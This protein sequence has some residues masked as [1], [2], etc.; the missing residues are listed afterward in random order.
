MV[1]DSIGDCFTRLRNGS[2]ARRESVE[3]PHSKVNEKILGLLKDEGF[4][5]EVSISDGIA[6]G[7]KA[8]HKVLV[9]KLKYES[10]QQPVLDHIRRVSKPGQRVYG[11]VPGSKGVREGLGFRILSTSKGILS[12]RQAVEQKVGGEIVGEVW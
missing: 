6:S 4:I 11:K 3:V 9:V 7:K 1:I 12:D 8:R 10:D 2:K 5:S